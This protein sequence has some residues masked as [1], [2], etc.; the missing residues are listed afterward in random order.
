MS[1]VTLSTLT[2]PSVLPPFD[3]SP[4]RPLPSTGATEAERRFPRGLVHPSD[5]PVRRQVWALLAGLQPP[6]K[7][8]ERRFEQR[9]PYPHMLYLTP[10]AME[11]ET[12]G[13]RGSLVV[14]GKHLS[15]SG[16]S[17]FHQQPLAH[18]RMTVSLEGGQGEWA[19]FLID[20]R[21]CRFTQHGWYE[22]GGQFL[23]TMRS[24]LND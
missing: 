12:I 22:S 8:V 9:F 21:W 10:L 20:I 18:R 7:W 6:G 11:G 14:V 1:T 2:I 23:E 15:E 16:L 5:H 13:R 4:A 19:G 17:F 24:P 3:P